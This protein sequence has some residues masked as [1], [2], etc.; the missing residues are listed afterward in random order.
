M[1]LGTVT[2]GRSAQHSTRIRHGADDSFV[3]SLAGAQHRTQGMHGTQ[4]HANW[5]SAASARLSNG[6]VVK[7][8]ERPNRAPSTTGACER[9]SPTLAVLISI[10]T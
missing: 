6:H 4:W 7:R 10:T 1:T 3:A 8:N 2:G 5:Y 9:V